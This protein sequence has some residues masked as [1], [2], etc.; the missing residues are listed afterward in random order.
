[1]RT[2]A[3]IVGYV[4]CAIGLLGLAIELHGRRTRDPRADVGGIPVVLAAALTW[5]ALG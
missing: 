3:L 1:M 5:H 4:L 2:T